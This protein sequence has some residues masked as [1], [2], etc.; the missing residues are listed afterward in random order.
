MGLQIIQSQSLQE[1]AGKNE[2][3]EIWRWVTNF[4]LN[5]PAALTIIQ[6]RSNRNPGMESKTSDCALLY[7]SVFPNNVKKNKIKYEIKE[8]LFLATI[9]QKTVTSFL[10]YCLIH[11]NPLTALDRINIDGGNLDHSISQA[12]C[13]DHPTHW[14]RSRHVSGIS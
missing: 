4:P 6:C 10:H 14:A 13:H 7:Q 3:L 1:Y 5:L 2:Y 12:H 11:R 9:S 8:S